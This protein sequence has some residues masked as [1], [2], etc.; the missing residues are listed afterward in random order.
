LISSL[1]TFSVYLSFSNNTLSVLSPLSRYINQP[2]N[3]PTFSPSPQISPTPSVL[4][5]KTVVFPTQN[6]PSDTSPWGIA[7]QIDEY[8]WTMKINQDPV[9]ATPKEIFNALN[10][11]RRVK[12]VSQLTWD[13]KLANYAQTRAQFFNQQKALDAHAGFQDF[14][15]NQNGFEFLGFTWLGENASFGYQMTGTHLI[16]WI[17]AGDEPHDQNQRDNRWAFVGVGVDGTAS[18][19]IFGTGKY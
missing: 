4:P 14:L 7:Q 9:M 3:Q 18:C 5:T 10:E 17:Y 8:T 15:E 12:G 6:I 19:L 1:T 2:I 11:Y 16:E 13:D